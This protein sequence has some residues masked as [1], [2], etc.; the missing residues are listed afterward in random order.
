[1]MIVEVH[2]LLDQAEAEYT[3]VKIQVG[4][5]IVDGGSDVMQSEERVF[6]QLL[7]RSEEC[8]WQPVRLGGPARVKEL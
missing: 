2:C 6:Q 3:D 1:M 4:L 5:S 7:G 8:R